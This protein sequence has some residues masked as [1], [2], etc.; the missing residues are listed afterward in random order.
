MISNRPQ[1]EGSFPNTTLLALS[2]PQGDDIMPRRGRNLS[3]SGIYHVMIRGNERKDIFLDGEDREKFI[4]T[5]AQK[6]KGGEYILYAYCLMDN[7]VHLVIKEGNDSISRTMKRINT[8]YAYYYNKKYDRIGH[9]F[10]DRY[11]SEAV[12]NEGYLVSVIRYVHN[13]PTKA[14]VC[15]NAEQYSWSSYNLYISQNNNRLVETSEILNI[16]SKEKEKSIQ[17]FISHTNE[18]NHDMYIEAEEKP[19]TKLKQEKVEEYIKRFQ[20]LHN[21][22][23]KIVNIM[24]NKAL[25]ESFIHYLK[26]QP[27]ISIRSISNVL[28][29]SRN[30]VQRVK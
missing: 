23:M 12:E 22:D 29:C 7:H 21:I 8:S 11:R 18:F 20:E 1:F 14:G 5:L 17:L 15:V 3:K 4:D 25:F 13:N 27:G 28:S 19:C 24:N 9:V 30:K 6:K 26:E 2:N 16:Y 10:Q